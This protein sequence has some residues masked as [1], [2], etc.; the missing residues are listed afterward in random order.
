MMGIDTLH[1]MDPLQGGVACNQGESVFC[2]VEL[3]G[4]YSLLYQGLSLY[5]GVPFVQWGEVF[6]LGI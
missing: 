1:F 2:Q 3:Q 5:G 6:N 4:L